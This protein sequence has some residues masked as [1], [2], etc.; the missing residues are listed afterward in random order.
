MS[1][2]KSFNSFIDSFPFNTATEF[3]VPLRMDGYELNFSLICLIV[4]L[5]PVAITSSN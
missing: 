2:D 3:L 4:R 5:L 1:Y